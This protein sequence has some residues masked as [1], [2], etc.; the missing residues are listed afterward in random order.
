MQSIL[1]ALVCGAASYAVYLMIVKLKGTTI[2][3][4][5]QAMESKRDFSR[6]KQAAP[7]GSYDEY[8]MS[9]SQTT[10]ACLLAG[11]VLSAIGFLF[12]KNIAIC[13]VLSLAAFYYPRIRRKQLIHKRKDELRQQFKHALYS[14]SSALSA[15]KSVENAFLEARGDLRLL[16]PDQATDMIVELDRVNRRTENGEPVEKSLL[17]FGRRSGIEDVQ[18]FAEAFAACKRTGGDLVEVM[19]RTSNLIGEKM[20]IEQDIRVM[21]AQKRFEAKA[22]GFIPFII[23][24]F[25]AFSSP[26]YMEP[27]YTGAGRLIMTVSLVILGASQWLA[28]TIMDIGT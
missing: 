15:G 22:L 21:V 19:R 24:A 8:A 9:V 1:V 11:I 25:L 20:E 14:L 4:R 23:V 17:D 16:Y 27:L 13:A 18:Q 26:D 3:T 10:T 28:H 5:F 2:W 7:S 12:Y 6:R